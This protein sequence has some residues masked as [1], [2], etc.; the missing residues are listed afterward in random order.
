LPTDCVN[1]AVDE[2][3]LKELKTYK[4]C[5]ANLERAK[6]K[7][8]GTKP[9][10]KE[11]KSYKLACKCFELVLDMIDPRTIEGVRV[12]HWTDDK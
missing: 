11:Y 4:E 9:G 1:F 8:A 2:V 5:K 7:L 10:T 6:Q 3:A 12:I